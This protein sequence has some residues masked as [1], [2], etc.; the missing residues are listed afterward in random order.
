MHRIV[1]SLLLCM[2]AA[3]FGYAQ[4]FNPEYLK[5]IAREQIELYK[6][7]AERLKSIA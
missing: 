4:E 3:S 5:Q 1:F 7:R 2:L 6:E